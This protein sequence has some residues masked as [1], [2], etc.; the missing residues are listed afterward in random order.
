MRSR[1]TIASLLA[2]LLI[3]LSIGALTYQFQER[4]DYRVGPLPGGGFVLPTN[5]IVTPA[6]TQVTFAGRPLALAVRPDNRTAAVLNTGS[7][8]S[9]FTTQPV[10]IV[11]LT[12]GT[13]KQ[14]FSPGTSNAS[15]DGVIYAPDGNH[16]YFSQDKGGIVVANVAADGTLS[17]NAMI[18]LPSSLGTVNNGGLA[19]SADG[20]TLYVVLNMTNSVGVIDLTTN[21]LTGTIPVENAPKSIAVMGNHAYV[22]NPGRPSLQATRVHGQVRGYVDRCRQGFRRLHYG[23]GERH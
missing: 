20:K 18:T 14:L 8:Q 17:L 13:L 4:P 9:N 6:G 3:A 19:L 1:S 16:L 2:L 12:T 22:S 11:D 7:G 15:Y 10:A 21:Q 5:Q 23:N